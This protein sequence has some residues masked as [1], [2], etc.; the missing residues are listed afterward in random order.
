MADTNY[1]TRDE[2]KARKQIA[3]ADTSRDAFIDQVIVAA[4]A[5]VDTYMGVPPGYFL[6]QTQTRLYRADNALC[7]KTDSFLSIDSLQCDLGYNRSYSAT[8][9]TT[10]YDVLPYNAALDG[11]AYREIRMRTTATTV[12]PVDIYEPRVRVTGS[13]GENADV[14]PQVKEAVFRIIDRFD[15]LRGNAFGVVG[16]GELGTF[17]VSPIDPEVAGLLD[18]LRDRGMA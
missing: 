2:V 6:P 5:K 8:F 9:A 10:Q 15:A 7:L 12:F 17:R 14:L 18:M 13:F 11:I 4:C 16:G 3:D 1:V